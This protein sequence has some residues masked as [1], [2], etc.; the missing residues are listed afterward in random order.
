M[1]YV[2]DRVSVMNDPMSF[3]TLEFTEKTSRLL[4][5]R[6]LEDGNESDEPALEYTP[7]TMTVSEFQEG[8]DTI[9]T[10]TR[11]EQYMDP[12]S[13]RNVIRGWLRKQDGKDYFFYLQYDQHDKIFVSEAKGVISALE[14]SGREAVLDA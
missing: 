4:T 1:T 5:L 6:R 12:G 11:V 8:L 13:A 3:D 9:G 7:L 14:Y 2:I 10:V